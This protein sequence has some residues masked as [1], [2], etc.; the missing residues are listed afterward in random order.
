MKKLVRESIGDILKPKSE[1]EIIDNLKNADP[2]EL[3]WKESS[4]VNFRGEE[5]VKFR[6][7][8]DSC[9]KDEWKSYPI[10][11]LPL[12]FQIWKDFKKRFPEN[13]TKKLRG[14][15][16]GSMGTSVDFSAEINNRVIWVQSFPKNTVM[17]KISPFKKIRD[18]EL[19]KLILSNNYMLTNM[20]Q[21]HKLIDRL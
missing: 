9:N 3:F 15:D 20:N 5:D 2:Y 1:K 19:K 7:I 14:N 4:P 17:F 18:R 8:E 12:I 13:V 16:L 6:D 10:E 11:A 21:Y